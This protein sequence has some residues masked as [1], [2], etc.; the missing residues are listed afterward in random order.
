MHIIHFGFLAP[1]IRI[2]DLPI[3]PIKVIG[4]FLAYVGILCYVFFIGRIRK[5]VFHLMYF[6][7][8]DF[9]IAMT[10][11]ARIRGEFVSA[12]PEVFRFIGLD[13][14]LISFGIAGIRL[15]QI[16]SS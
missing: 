14:V 1:S 4:G 3:V 8:V 13:I 12:D 11:L 2:N 9:V 15:Y 7:Y 10:F 6:Y 5:I 16:R